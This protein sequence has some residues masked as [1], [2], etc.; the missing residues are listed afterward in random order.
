MT[1]FHFSTALAIASVCLTPLA[2]GQQPREKPKELE[3]LG[4]YVGDWTSDVTGKPAVWTPEE[5]KFRT[6]NHAE[7]VLD[8]WF[9]Q[10][11]E[12]N[13]VVGDPEKVTKALWFQTFDPRSEAFVMWFFQSTGMIGKATGTWNQK[14]KSLLFTPTELSPN[15]TGKHTEAFPNDRTITGSYLIIETDDRT[16]FDMVWTRKRQAG[17]AGKPTREQWAKIGTPIEPVPDQMKKLQPFIGEWDSEF[18]QRP[19][20]V[21]PDG[22]TSKG[23][24]TAKW[25]LDG[26]FLFGTTEVGNHNSN[27]VMGYDTNKNAYRYIRF[28]NTGLIDESTGQWNEE[29]RSFVWKLVNAPS[30]ITR[31]STNRIVGKDAIHAHILAEKKDDTVHMNLTIR[32]TRRKSS[33]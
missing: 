23:T 30:G 20:V 13:H 10:H 12:V 33:L 31:T 3:V 14:N 28:T 9:V 16:L 26:R 5:K 6:I 8:G 19:S 11:I 24:M 18:I 17:V 1:K 32:T 2:F 4:R 21:S 29:T 7:F 15:A 27:W 22:N 25:I